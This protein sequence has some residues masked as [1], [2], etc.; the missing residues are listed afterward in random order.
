MDVNNNQM[1]IYTFM[2]ISKNNFFTK[3]KLNKTFFYRVLCKIIIVCGFLLSLQEISFQQS[4]FFIFKLFPNKSHSSALLSL[5]NFPDSVI[6][7]E[8][9]AFFAEQTEEL[10]VI[11][12]SIKYFYN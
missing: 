10:I 7:S 6:M 11:Y 8:I 5:A 3:N 2:T 4:T 1:F 12:L 9:F